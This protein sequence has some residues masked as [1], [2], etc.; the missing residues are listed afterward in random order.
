[1]QIIDP[2]TMNIKNNYD[3]LWLQRKIYIQK[4]PKWQG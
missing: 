3:K 4:N 1:M 2:Q